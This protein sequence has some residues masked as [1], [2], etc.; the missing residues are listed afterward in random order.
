L[1]RAADALTEISLDEVLR[2]GWMA[3]FAST[4]LWDTESFHAISARH[5]QLV[6]DA[7][8]VAQL[9]LHLW[10]L[11]L[12]SMW[13]GDFSGAASLAAESESVAEATGGHLPLYTLLR[14]RALQ[15]R[16]AEFSAVL[17]NASKHAAVRGQGIIT[18]GHWGA[19]VLFNGLGR[20]EEAAS[21]AAAAASDTVTR[22]PSMWALPELVEAAAR[23]GDVER[24]NDALERLISTTQPCE[25][26]F[27]RGI[28]ARCRAVLSDGAAADE[29]Y[30]HA[31]DRLSRT[32]L[33]PDLAR[34]HL[35]YGEWLRREGRRVDA[36]R[37]LRTAHELLAAMGME[38]FAE[39]ARRELVATGEKVRRHRRDDARH[40]LTPQEEQIAR[41]ARDGLSNP[42]IG[43]QL[44]ISGRTVEWHLR[45]VFTKLDI[46]SRTQL[47]AALPTDGFA[48]LARA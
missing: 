43:A 30:R 28:E 29:L 17:A 48:V 8:A 9:P 21:E 16:E 45:K 26:D 19:A 7:G 18:S 34:A 39:R 44:F 1:K 38:A 40:H 6:R 13:T 20:Y 2:W 27:A 31:V 35:L 10:Q 5:V 4:M 23:C 41:L 22:R 15:G 24:A 11:A 12:L 37:Q 32:R 14:L 46:S 25:T 47:R 3:T 33:R 36:R 42:A